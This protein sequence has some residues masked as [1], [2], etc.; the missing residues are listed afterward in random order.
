MSKNQF[1][2]QLRS[3][4]YQDMSTYYCARDTVKGPQCEPDTNLPAE[5]QGHQRALSTQGAQSQPSSSNYWMHWVRQAPG[6]ELEWVGYISRDGGSTYFPDSVKGRFTISRDNSKNTLY[7][8]MSSLRAEDTATYYCA[9]DTGAQ[10]QQGALSTQRA[11]IHTGAGVQCEVQL[12][13]S[14]GGLVQPGGTL[15]LSCAASGFTFSSYW[16]NRFCWALQKS[17][18][19][20]GLLIK[21]EVKETMLTQ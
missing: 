11:Q 4:T 9:R 18:G 12:V 3:L 17:L 20:L 13:E 2:L 19:L 16:M 7:L 21:K 5:I 15:R 8:Q 6:K 1:S 10:G 14:G